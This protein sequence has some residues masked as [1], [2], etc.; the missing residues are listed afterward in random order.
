MSE[1]L[2]MVSIPRIES[3]LTCAA[4]FYIFN[5]SLRGKVKE[6]TVFFLTMIVSTTSIDFRPLQPHLH[7]L[8]YFLIVFPDSHCIV[9]VY[10]EAPLIVRTMRMLHLILLSANHMF[11]AQN[12]L[13][14]AT[15]FPFP[16]FSVTFWC[17]D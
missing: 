13:Q 6:V 12:V 11:L 3:I 16:I 17:M 2:Y 4:R 15:F 8:V 14:P 1:R 10:Y 9:G 7:H 5:L